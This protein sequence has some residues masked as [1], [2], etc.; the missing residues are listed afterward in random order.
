M[1]KVVEKSIIDH[2]MVEARTYTTWQDKQVS[3][4]QLTQLIDIMKMEPTSANCSPARL[5]F[6]K[7]AAAKQRLRRYLTEGN[8]EKTMS[9]PCPALIKPV[10]T[11]N[12]LPAQPINPIFYAILATAIQIACIRACHASHS[13]R[14]LKFFN[15]KTYD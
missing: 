15:F 10:S 7:S 9:A 13:T 1:S 12:S 4:E 14:W 11:Q 5:V 3:D 2:L 8:V 6:V